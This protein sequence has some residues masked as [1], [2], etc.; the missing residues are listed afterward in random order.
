MVLGDRA[1]LRVAEVCAAFEVDG[2][3]AD[4]VTARAAMA[5]AAWSGRT[6]VAAADIRA[7]ARLALPH[8]RRRN[9]FDPPRLSDEQLDKALEA[10]GLDDPDPEPDPPNSGVDPGAATGAGD[11]NVGDGNVGDGTV[12][13]GAAGDGAAGDSSVES[14]VETDPASAAA[15]DPGSGA[16]STGTG[17]Q[18]SGVGPTAVAGVGE[19]YRARL[20]TVPGTGVGVSGR[21]SRALTSTGQTVRTANPAAAR[22]ARPDLVAT[23]RAAA[24]HQR[25]RG[26]RGPGLLVRPVDLRVAVR[27]GREGN[28]ILFCVDASGSMA[29]R[30]RM[31]EVKTAVLSLLIDA[32]LRRDKVGLVTF[33]AAGAELALPPTSSVDV[34]AARL[35]QLP[36]G[37]RTPLAEGLLRAGAA[38][39][40]EAIRDPRRRQLLV[41]VTD[42]RATAG[43]DAVARARH[44]A[45]LLAA[46]AIHAVVLDCESGRV[47]LGL[48][49]ELAE[50]MRAQHL[51]LAEVAASALTS[52]VRAATAPANHT[53]RAA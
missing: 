28:L 45:G 40:V 33:R 35:A 41:V 11:G 3:R 42:G 50:A 14:A 19:A 38:L 1:L 39:R 48:A 53:R 20:L 7:A 26:R 17:A 51:P 24:P 43:P 29:A 34:A 16:E 21:R 32:Y 27:E 8:R 18:G 2:M 37:G 4:L 12:G 13:D 23:L 9:P 31:R 15:G 22:T 36:T 47:R 10:A 25:A 44:A 30:A 6:E 49:G 5:H 46:A 52:T